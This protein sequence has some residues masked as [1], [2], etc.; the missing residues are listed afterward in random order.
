MSLSTLNLI[1]S[2]STAIAVDPPSSYREESPPL[3]SYRKMKKWFPPQFNFYKPM[4]CGWSFTIA[5]IFSLIVFLFTAII[6]KLVPL[7]NNPVISAVQTDR[8]YC[9]LVPLTL[10]VLAVAAYFHW[11]SMK[12][13]KHA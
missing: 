3:H 9:F 2:L 12:L 4:C 10:P 13:F 6:S 7:S 1:L 8:Y 5:G 11:L